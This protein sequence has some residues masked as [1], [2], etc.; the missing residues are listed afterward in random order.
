MLEVK[1]KY[2][3]HTNYSGQIQRNETKEFQLQNI[4]NEIIDDIIQVNDHQQVLKYL[5]D[6]EPTGDIKSH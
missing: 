5:I 4:F 2:L 3:H 6:A 1:D